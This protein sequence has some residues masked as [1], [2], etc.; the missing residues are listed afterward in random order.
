MFG[1]FKKQ[2]DLE[3]HSLAS[4][5]RRKNSKVK[6]SCDKSLKILKTVNSNEELARHPDFV[7]PFI[8][9]CL[10]KSN[11]LATISL[12]CLQWLS[13]TEIIP[14]QRVSDVLDGL[15]DATALSADIQLKV[16]QIVPLFFQTYGRHIYGDQLAK[17][18]QCC[19]NL[20]QSNIK[21]SMLTGTASASLQQLIDE[22]FERLSYD[23]SNKI[24]DEELDEYAV[25]VNN[26]DEIKINV[27]RYDANCLFANLISLMNKNFYANPNGSV[28][29]A[30]H[31]QDK[32]LLGVKD[33]PI[34]Y[35]LEIL[36]SLLKNNRQAFL[37]YPDLQF[38]L[39]V[40]AIPLLLRANS[41][42]KNFPITLRSFRCFGFLLQKEFITILESEIEVIFAILIQSLQIS[43]DKP[44]W[45]CV[46][47]LELLK[48]LMEDFNV[49]FSLY[50]NYDNIKGKKQII[51]PLLTEC[52][53]ILKSEEYYDLLAPS[54][55]IEKMKTPTIK[56]D[57]ATTNVQFLH[58]LDKTFAP[59]VDP[60][61][62][63]WLIITISSTL[64]DDLSQSAI[65]NNKDDELKNIN[66]IYNGLFN[67]LFELN[68]ILIYS[69]AIDTQLFQRISTSLQMLTHAAGSLKLNTKLDQYLE[70]LAKV[71]V[72]NSNI[73]EMDDD[74]LTL[75][76]KTAKDTLTMENESFIEKNSIKTSEKIFL[77]KRN[78]N[79]R[80]ASLFETLASLSL[81]LG[82]G[83]QE[84]SW[85]FFFITWQWVSYYIY[86]PSIDF[87]ESHYSQDIPT[88]P[89]IS[90]NDI[91]SMEISVIKILESTANFS[92]DE[93]K[94]LT[95][96][97]ID[98][99]NKA[100]FE[101]DKH[102]YHPLSNSNDLTFCVYNKA[103][104]ITQMGELTSY[105]FKRFLSEE[106]GI[107]GYWQIMNYFISLI[108][109]RDS[110]SG[111]LRPYLTAI[112]T[113][114]IK[115]VCN[116]V[117]N[118][119]DQDIRK[120][121]FA[122]AETLIMD[123]LL[124][125]I[126]ELSKSTTTKDDIYQGTINSESEIIL[127]LLSTLKGILN[128]FG[129][130][131][132]SSWLIV[133][134]ITN[135]P[136][137]VFNKKIV[138]A[139]IDE[140]EDNALLHAILQKR[141]ELIQASYD[142]FKLISDDFLQTLPVDTMQ[143]LIKT[144]VNYV[145][146]DENLN[147]SFSSISQFWLVGDY[148][149]NQYKQEFETNSVDVSFESLTNKQLMNIISSKDVNQHEF[150]IGIWIYLLK[151]LISCSSDKRIEVKNGAIQTFFRII[152]SHQ[153]YL[154]NWKL[155]FTMVLKPL[156]TAKFMQ[157][158]LNHFADF[159][160][161][162][163]SGLINIYPMTLAAF[164]EDVIF[165]KAWLTLLDFIK[166]LLSVPFPSVKFVAVANLKKLL[167]AMTKLDNIPINILQECFSLF[168]NYNVIYSDTTDRTIPNSKTEYDCIYE[169]MTVFPYLHQLMKKFDQISY[170]FI[171]GSLNLFNS[172][173]KFPLLPQY[174]KDKLKPSSL[175]DSILQ[176]I[177]ILDID[178]SDDIALV[179]LFHISSLSTLMFD[180]RGKILSKLADKL[181]ENAMARIPTFE[182]IS[183]RAMEFLNEILNNR[184]PIKVPASKEK[185]LLRTFKNLLD[186]LQKKPLITLGKNNEN[187][188][189]ILASE[190]IR[191]LSAWIFDSDIH[192]AMSKSFQDTFH[193]M[194]IDA[195][196]SPLATGKN[197]SED[198]NT[199]IDDCNEYTQYKSL[200]IKRNVVVK[201]GK[202]ALK[203]FVIS[204]WKSSFLYQ[205][206]DLENEI[207]NSYDDIE[208]VTKKFCTL[209]LDSLFGST[210]EPQDLTK[211]RC[212]RRCL[213]DLI[214]FVTLEGDEYKV[215]KEIT[216]PYLTCRI[217]IL[218]TKYIANE[219][220]IDRAPVTKL[221][222]IELLILLNGLDK[223]LKEILEKNEAK[224]YGHD[225]D[226]ILVLYPL[227]LKTI[228]VSH[229]VD[230]LQELVLRLSLNFT[231]LTTNELLQSS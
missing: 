182:A 125:T 154:P 9:A 197:E 143:S 158:E 96:S 201:F 24:E 183:Y 83:L 86:G 108:A 167:E 8:E 46:L 13:S 3:L 62:I 1:P 88:G 221:R 177:K 206:D 92:N 66:I 194:Y 118:E 14:R 223:I 212:R 227:I 219:R 16:L 140:Q 63:I 98:S 180:T 123:S 215:L 28:A 199:E 231:K 207:L 60:T 87:M 51:T 48:K 189:W 193:Q 84:H 111:P 10:S 70:F 128:E 157:D 26:N 15:L 81:T 64:S 139:E 130:L 59:S 77:A 175:Q 211:K 124:N 161:L 50:L 7:L 73:E 214:E 67:V 40:K 178:Q 184:E 136:F 195:I 37:K 6:H 147:I 39:R 210:V 135:A 163:L 218:L 101:E 110:N 122:V 129:D 146:Q 79:S 173:S 164:D 33:M 198:I 145:T 209:N 131:L 5:A 31:T 192:D 133:L 90:K 27:Y 217:S 43:Q 4:E 148:L 230:G 165:S 150:Y 229:K 91:S 45:H 120:E 61:Y 152:D 171:D 205:F 106:K 213:E 56:N 99:S 181:N 55:L 155:I 107:D 19:S 162:T 186:V 225:L 68:A 100:I 174:T 137:D 104:Y 115:N 47:S 117:D 220:L 17:L 228:P 44:F 85:S 127:Q 38:L 21:S 105:N 18:L 224:Q 153:S 22:I 102:N 149:R 52:L 35:G 58:M 76:S 82:P 114:I 119:E 97:L 80:Q 132:T 172:T 126:T 103:F 89:T 216:S 203:Q 12:Q 169:L 160:D 222:R 25:L 30:N 23:W 112:F 34:D 166:R 187:P 144:L 159:Y 141:I 179:V 226:G 32:N 191:L 54:K 168:S 196:C 138:F 57:I 75:N 53:N 176:N 93:F 49:I 151:S 78:F 190:S 109:K 185:H 74:N 41:S 65:E 20:F 202:D 71:T 11:R 142:V 200:L 188:L 134:Q 72:N 69:T 208:H 95:N 116:E 156:L 170:T 204:I 2:L 94:T 42:T 29:D 121:K 36:E 113:D